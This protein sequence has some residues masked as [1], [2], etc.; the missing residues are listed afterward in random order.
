MPTTASTWRRSRLRRRESSQ[1]GGSYTPEFLHDGGSVLRWLD[2]SGNFWNFLS[3]PDGGALAGSYSAPGGAT[4]VPL[5]DA[6][7]STIALVNAAQTGSPPATT[8]IYDP[9]GN[10]ALSE[11]ASVHNILRKIVAPSTDLPINCNR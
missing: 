8:Y 6:S 3:L 1:G 2:S 11:S 9:S 5:I 7:G 10:P 4:W